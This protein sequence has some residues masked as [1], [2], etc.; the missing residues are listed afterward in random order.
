MKT[1]KVQHVCGCCFSEA[2]FKNDESARAAFKQA[3]LGSCVDIVDDTG[4]VIEGV[5]TFYGFY[6]A[7]GVHESPL[8][9]LVNQLRK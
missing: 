3:G 8:A 1:Y 4:K 7:H 2:Q 9:K 6:A 5:D